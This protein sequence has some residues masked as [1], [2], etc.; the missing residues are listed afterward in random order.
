MAALAPILIVDDDADMRDTLR[1]LLEADG[2]SVHEASGSHEMQEKLSQHTF[3]LILLDQVL[4]GGE[5]GISILR[6]LR[7]SLDIPVIMLT[8]KDD[9][10]DKIV[11]L[12]VGADDYI[13]KPFHGRELTARIKN[14]L[15]RRVVPEAKSEKASPDTKTLTFNG[16]KLDQLAR[17][18]QSPDGNFVRLTS[19]EYSIL[20]LLVTRA[21]R[22][23][24]RDRLLDEISPGAQDWSPLDRSPDVLIA[25]L[26]K[27]LGDNPKDPA[28][29]RTVRQAGYIFIA[30]VEL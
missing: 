6:R 1:A 14:I 12:E 19:H 23:L 24:S 7:P 21:G 27:K 17:K 2:F 4:P 10:I 5:D 22:I 15:R 16:W 8:G 25:K 3:S 11:G 18:L 20:N 28:F 9:V 13:T 26:R 30:P 29:I